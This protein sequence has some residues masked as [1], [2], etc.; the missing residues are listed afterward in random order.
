[1]QQFFAP[2]CRVCRSGFFR[3]RCRGRRLSLLLALLGRG[4]G[5]RLGRFVGMALFLLRA[6]RHFGF[7]SGAEPHPRF[8]REGRND[9]LVV[10]Q[11]PVQFVLGVNAHL[12]VVAVEELGHKAVQRHGLGLAGALVL[13]ALLNVLKHPLGKLA[14]VPDLLHFHCDKL[15]RAAV[16]GHGRGL[17]GTAHLLIAVFAAQRRCTHIKYHHAAVNV[18]HR[19]QCVVFPGALGF[20]QILF[21]Q[22][23]VEPALLEFQHVPPDQIAVRAAVTDKNIRPFNIA[24]CDLPQHTVCTQ[25]FHANFPLCHLPRSFLIPTHSLS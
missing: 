2:L 1:M 5:L 7:I 4:L 10:V 12:L 23:D 17:H 16:Q 11:L 9:L 8:I 6:Y 18:L 22:P 20:V 14:D 15:D 19:F 3:P 21:V 25:F 13:P 24:G